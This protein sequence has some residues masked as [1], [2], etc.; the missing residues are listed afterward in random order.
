[1]T[2]VRS[3]G[4]NLTQVP[5]DRGRPPTE[6]APRGV[7][8]T[9]RLSGFV[10]LVVEAD[11]NDFKDKCFPD[12]YM[13]EDPTALA[14]FCGSLSSL[15]KHVRG[16]LRN[17]L[18]TN[19]LK[20]KRFHIEGDVPPLDELI[21]KVYEEFTKNLKGTQP[22]VKITWSKRI[23][24]SHLR[25]ETS[26]DF[27]QRHAQLV[28]DKDAE[29]FLKGQM[30]SDVSHEAVVMPTLDNVTNSLIRDPPTEDD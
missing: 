21:K 30:F 13:D 6:S 18:L 28:I 29:L 4:A 8:R 27:Q 2:K 16:Q 23:C 25:L 5:P 19:I 15:I 14:V 10:K 7:P 12:G 24:F 9:L 3:S 20:N 26:I 22:S 17:V 11:L 1:M